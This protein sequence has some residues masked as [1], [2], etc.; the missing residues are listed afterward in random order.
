MLIQICG[1]FF[2]ALGGSVGGVV[3][4]AQ[5]GEALSR[6]RVEFLESG[7]RLLTDATG[8]FRIDDVAPGEFTVHVSTVGYRLLEKHVRLEPGENI[9]LEFIL[10]PETFRRTDRVEVQGSAFE[11]A[12]RAAGDGSFSIQGREAKNLASVLADDPLRAVQTAPGVSSNDDFEARFS[13]HGAPYERIGLYL[14]GILLHAPFHTVQGEGPSGSMA[15]FN[16]D[17][18]EE[19]SLQSEGYSARYG[20][21][22]A[23]SLDI[24]TR[25]GSRA[26]TSGRVTAGVAG[27][28]ALAEGPLGGRGSWLASVRKSYLQYLV[29]RSAEEPTVA[30]AFTDSQAQASYDLNR[31]HSINLGVVDGVSNF[32]RSR[33]R[34]RLAPNTSMRAGYRFTLANL[35][36]QYAPSSVFLLQSHAAFMRERYDDNNRWQ[37]ALGEGFY[38]EW[39]GNSSATWMWGHAATLEFGGSVRRIRGDGS[40]DYFLDPARSVRVEGHRGK[41]WRAGGYAQQSWSGAGNRLRLLLGARWDRAGANGRTVFSP[42]ASAA[43]SP[44]SDGRLQFTWGRY[45]QF[46]DVAYLF[47]Q[48]GSPSLPPAL[49]THYIASFEQR[50]G[51]V[52]RLRVQAYRREDRNLLFRPHEEARL[53]PGGILGDNFQAPLA[54][55]LRGYARGLEFFVQRRTANRLTGWVSYTLGFARMQDALTGL[56]FPSDQDQR[57]TVNVY[58]GCRIRPSVNLSTKWTYGSGFPIPGFFEKK[59]AS[60]YLSA[61]RNRAR[62]DSYE[63][64]D[65]RLN[66]ERVFER[67]KMTVYAE[68]VNVF[69]RPNSRFDSYNGYDGSTRQAYLSFSGMFPVLPSAGLTLEF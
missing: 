4:D 49:A 61:E 43:F 63:R 29:Q 37:R 32:D 23:G 45:A 53:T 69:N 55:S 50:I 34:D 25:D 28:G 57:H 3:R 11:F 58:L 65:V 67:W 12:E 9:E 66:K 22:T 2:L 17:M 31:S 26:G 51:P 18:V 44:W 38:G 56:R 16:G 47:S 13:L 41:D 46:P 21:R 8:A 30:F 40:A 68:V 54:G 35:G 14:D 36:W 52:S 19:M 59:G 64:T 15:V 39:V 7:R 33:W 5:T 60:Y 6:V 62:L 1:L 27:A 24:H 10:S 20:D 48:Y 42:Q